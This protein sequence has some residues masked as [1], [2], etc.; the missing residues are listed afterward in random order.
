MGELMHHNSIYEQVSSEKLY[1]HILKTEGI[2]HYKINPQ[3]L[4]NCADYLAAEFASYG[5]ATKSHEFTVDGAPG[6]FRNIEAVLGDQSKPAILITS[7]YDTIDSSPGANDNG[8]GMAAMLEAARVLAGSSL[9]K[10]CVRFVCFT[11]EELHPRPY[12]A[13]Y[14]KLRECALVD[15]QRRY[16][17]NRMHQ[18]VKEFYR[19]FRMSL[20]KGSGYG[21]ATASAFAVVQPGLETH[22]QEYFRHIAGQFAELKGPAD[23]IG[24]TAIVGS[25]LYVEK[26]LEEKIAMEAVLNLETIGYTSK[27]KNSQRLPSPL[28]KLLPHYRTSFRKMAGDFICVVGDKNSRRLAKVFCRQCRL[29]GI[30]LPYA[31]IA[32]PLDFDGIA[33]RIRTIL[34]S[35]HAPFWRTGIPAL[36]ITDT[37]DYRFPFYH[38]EADTIDKLD[39]GFIRKVCQASVAAVLELDARH[40]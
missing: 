1:A 37:A 16:K 20:S 4:D 22:E 5:L 11:L 8:S 19:A 23:W 27:L 39:F 30:E 6:S 24:K 12:E 15:D 18:A 13:S 29:P 17:T 33:R 34:R 3:A 32:L 7:H 14:Q 26:A 36:M 31:R 38:T 9:K 25:T 40:R 35:D 2:K 28:F 10:H 21:A